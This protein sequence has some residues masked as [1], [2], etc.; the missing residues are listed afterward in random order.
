[1]ENEIA[2]ALEIGALASITCNFGIIHK[3]YNWLVISGKK[4]KITRKL[5]LD[6]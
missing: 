4:S 5:K 2:G 3:N 1:M 6:L